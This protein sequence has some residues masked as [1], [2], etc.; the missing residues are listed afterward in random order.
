MTNHRSYSN[1]AFKQAD[2][3]AAEGSAGLPEMRPDTPEPEREDNAIGVDE[4]DDRLFETA[5]QASLQERMRELLGRHR[6][7]APDAAMDV[8]DDDGADADAE[9]TGP[10]RPRSP[11]PP[12]TEF[13]ENGRLTARAKGKG[14]VN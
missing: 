8:D 1:A 9:M 11:A 14:R 12:P 3:P 13:H 4:M 5:R 2:D 10:A 6:V 7:R